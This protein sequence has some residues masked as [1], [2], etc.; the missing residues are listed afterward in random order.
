MDG[1]S[2]FTE[3]INETHELHKIIDYFKPDTEFSNNM[4]EFDRKDLLEIGKNYMKKKGYN[5]F[6]NDDYKNCIN[7]S[8]IEHSVYNVDGETFSPFCQHADD[9]GGIDGCVNTLILYYRFSKDVVGGNLSIFFDTPVPFEIT[10]PTKITIMTQQI[11][12][13]PRP[14]QYKI[15]VLCIRGDI[16]HDIEPMHGCG[17]RCCVVLQYPCERK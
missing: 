15:C 13:D 11:I 3:Y 10:E 5:N 12:V 7:S 6:I 8:L 16:K 9:N 17:K 4:E 14:R 2:F 1:P